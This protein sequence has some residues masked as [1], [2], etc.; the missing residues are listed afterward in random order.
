MEKL[1]A[2]LKRA[3]SSRESGAPD[4]GKRHAADTKPNTARNNTTAALWT[5]LEEIKLSGKAMLKH[6]IV[7]QKASEEATP[8]DILRTKIL[9]Q[10][11]QNSWKSLAITSPMP[12]CGKTT[13]ACNL[14]LGLGRQSGLHTILFDMDLRQPTLHSFLDHKPEMDISDMLCGQVS[15][16]QQAVRVGANVAVSLASR[17]EADPTQTLLSEKTKETL[18]DIR[19]T[20]EPDITIFDMPSILVGDNT[21]AFLKNVDCALVVARANTTRYGHFDACEREIA[22]NTNVLG[23]VLNAFKSKSIESTI[24]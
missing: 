5:D 24:E 11:R 3:R 16:A 17:Q 10:M 9:L 15:F 23:V 6:N 13:T 7:T 2:A 19:N 1:Q 12:Q 14:A 18:E 20:Y 4:T 8:F 21:R 22:E